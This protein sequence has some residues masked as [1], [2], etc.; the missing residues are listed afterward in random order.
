[1]P[2][3]SDK[4]ITI[5]SASSIDEI[6]EQE[7]DIYRHS[8]DQPFV[9]VLADKKSDAPTKGKGAADRKWDEEVRKSLASKQKGGIP[10]LSKTDQAAVKAQLAKE[11]DVRV[12]V[13]ASVSSVKQALSIIESM[14][15]SP[16]EALVE[17]LPA[18]IEALGAFASKHLAKLVAS[19]V[20]GL[21]TVSDYLSIGSPAL[22]TV[23][24]GASYTLSSRRESASG[25]CR[26]CHTGVPPCGHYA[27]WFRAC[28]FG[29]GYQRSI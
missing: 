7:I 11:A 18:V 22:L 19:D 9:N 27:R 4:A 1:M 24:T 17:E 14:L 25:S 16:D 10:I 3:I 28:D 8:G 23:P 13:G 2:D 21:W 15:P 29:Y 26:E 20:L 12:L 5:L 6:R